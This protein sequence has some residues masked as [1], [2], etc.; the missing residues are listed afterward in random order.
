MHGGGR[1]LAKRRRSRKHRGHGN[2]CHSL[3][4]GIPLVRFLWEA[5]DAPEL[6]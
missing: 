5:R 4:V 2:D 6:K 1:A 3:H